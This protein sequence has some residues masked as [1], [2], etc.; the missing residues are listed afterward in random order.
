MSTY[1]I[2]SAAVVGLMAADVSSGVALALSRGVF[3]SREM[4]AGFWRKVSELA[5]LFGL[6][7]AEQVATVAGVD[8]AAP[9]G[10]L[11]GC[12]YVAT[13]ETASVIE[14]LKSAAGGDAE[15]EEEDNED[16]N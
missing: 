15:K 6:I 9:F 4:R 10:F 13:M 11:G 5:A 7:G 2:L 12:A 16:R 8:L 3:R 1:F 14:N